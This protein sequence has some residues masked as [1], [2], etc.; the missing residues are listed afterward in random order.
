MNDYLV[1]VIAK[2]AGVRLLAAR[3]TTL[4]E[5]ARRRHMTD[6]T[7]TTALAR[8]L[9]GGAL[10]GAT[11]K[12]GQRVALKFDGEGPLRKIIVESDHYGRLRGYVAFPDVD[13]PARMGKDQ[14]AR[15][16]GPG[17]LT[18]V[19]DL[20]LKELSESIV[21]LATSEIDKDIELYLN[22]SEQIPSY[23][24]VGALL[25]EDGAI[26]M[27]GGVAIQSLPK[28]QTDTIYELVERMQELP[29]IEE[30]LGSGQSPDELAALILEGIPYRRLEEFPLYFQCNCSRERSMKALTL[31]GLEDLEILIAEGE[32]TVDC[33]YCHDQ[34][35][36]TKEE[37]EALRDQM[38]V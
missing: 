8:A 31:L 20:R 14:V 19:K 26:R 15:A 10:V 6:S 13:L 32:A 35:F 33:H 4:A 11:L 16:L 23:V 18:V 5:E 34:Y 1:R 17:T 3:T 2:D 38:E 22:Q 27:S 7:S 24:S 28:P 25:D 29:P 37:L 21:P 12:V 36:F 9:T 30:L